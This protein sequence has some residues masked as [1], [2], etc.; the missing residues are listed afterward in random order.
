MDALEQVYPFGDML[1]YLANESEYQA[2]GT[3][4]VIGDLLIF[5]HLSKAFAFIIIRIERTP[6]GMLA[7]SVDHIRPIGQRYPGTTITVYFEVIE[8]FELSM[9]ILYAIKEVVLFV[10]LVI[11]Y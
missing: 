7:F 2:M 9:V 11:A 5:N 8:W 6:A 3:V 10:M 1:D 4:S